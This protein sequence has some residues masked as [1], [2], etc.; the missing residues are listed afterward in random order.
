[1]NLYTSPHAYVTV[2]SPRLIEGITRMS[3]SPVPN[4]VPDLMGVLSTRAFAVPA[5]N[6]HPKFMPPCP[7]TSRLVAEVAHCP[8]KIRVDDL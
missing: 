5:M 2:S 3:N 1:M 8:T 6:I 7:S 4:R